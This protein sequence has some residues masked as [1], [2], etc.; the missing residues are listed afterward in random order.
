[1]I[2]SASSVDKKKR[3]PLLR[4]PFLSNKI[5]FKLKIDEFVEPLE[6]E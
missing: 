6:L 1:M 3:F 5:F 4:K 2:N